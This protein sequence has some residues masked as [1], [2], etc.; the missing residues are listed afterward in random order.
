M[1]ISE[2][3]ALDTAEIQARL[4]DAREEYFRLRMQFTTGQLT[5]HA[6]L[7]LVRRD[8]A[9]LSTIWRERQLAAALQG[10]DS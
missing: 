9:R 7:R 1:K 3:R 10:S 5:D 8:I 2:I 4:A 6:R